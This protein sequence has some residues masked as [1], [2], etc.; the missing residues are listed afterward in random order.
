MSSRAIR[1]MSF[2][3]AAMIEASH[4]DRRQDA[5][6]LLIELKYPTQSSQHSHETQLEYGYL[7]GVGE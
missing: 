7:Q 1:C 3:S 2:V 6:K 5:G 4:E